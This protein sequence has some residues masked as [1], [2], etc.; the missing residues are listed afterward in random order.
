VGEGFTIYDVQSFRLDRPRRD[1]PR[2][3]AGAVRLMWAAGRREL[4]TVVAAEALSAVAL[5]ATVLLDREVLAGVL[6]ADRAGGGWS[7]FLPALVAS[8]RSRPC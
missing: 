5:A 8:P 6:A 2:L 7:G 1:L 4:L 3:V